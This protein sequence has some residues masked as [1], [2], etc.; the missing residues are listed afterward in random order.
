MTWLDAALTLYGLAALFAVVLV[1]A[2]G[3]PL[4]VPSDAL[5]LAAAVGAA[6]GRFVPWHAFVALFIAL[7][8]GGTIQYGLARGPGC[9]LIARCGPY[10]GLAPRRVEAASATLGRSGVLG[11]GVAVFTPGVRTVTI[12]AC[13]VAAL[14]VAT[15]VPG[16]ALGSGLFLATHFAIGYL[17]GS[18]W[19]FLPR[20]STP[21]VA[22]GAL[23]LLAAAFALWVVIRRCRAHPGAPAVEAFAAWQEA[24]CPAC[25]ALG[26]T[27][28]AGK[29]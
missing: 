12:P 9:G 8:L 22:L 26:A 21:A 6:Q 2:I 10:V 3:V 28:P 4:P 27:L 1:K 16:L 17:G 25:L 15:F 18:L 13:G 23:I 11:V 14:P 24:A 7:V 20:P 19:S 29:H 5:M